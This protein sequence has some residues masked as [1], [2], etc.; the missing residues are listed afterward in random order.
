MCTHKYNRKCLT[1]I[2]VHL[3]VKTFL[4]WVNGENSVDWMFIV[5]FVGHGNT[6]R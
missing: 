6:V 5:V 4:G 1:K 2:I 3:E